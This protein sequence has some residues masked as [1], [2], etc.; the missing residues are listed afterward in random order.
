MKQKFNFERYRNHHK[1]WKLMLRFLIYT[2]VISI[3]LYM[4]LSQKKSSSEIIPED[5]TTIEYFDIIEPQSE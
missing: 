5:D 2:L 3:L 4:I 1:N